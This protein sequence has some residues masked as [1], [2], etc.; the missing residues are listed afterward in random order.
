MEHLGVGS[1]HEAAA[2]LLDHFGQ[3]SQIAN[4]DRRLPRERFDDDDPESF[5]RQRWD[6]T[7]DRVH[8]ER[9]EFGLREWT[10]ELDAWIRRSLRLQVGL[11]GSGA[12]DEQIAVL[13]AVPDGDECL[14][15]LE[16]F[17]PADEQTIR[18]LLAAWLRL[19]PIRVDA[20]DEVRQV[21][22]GS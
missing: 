1:V 11:I 17:E 21:P 18:M 3:R 6:D 15:P 12:S 4:D 20:I 19:L 8:V 13:H 10:Q 16:R 22:D 5:I 14:K 7:C 9:S 2:G